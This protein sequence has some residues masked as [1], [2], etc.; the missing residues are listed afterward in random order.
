MRRIL[1]KPEGPWLIA[2]VVA[3]ALLAAALF[4]PLWKMELVAP[5]YPKGLIMKAYGDR[6]QG[7][8]ST[9]YEDVREINGLNHYIGMKPIEEVTE[10]GLFVPGVV[11][12]IAGTV[13]VSFV[14][15]K[16]KWLKALILASFWFM[17]VFFVADLQ[18]WLY[19]YGHTM[20]PDAALDTGAFTPK[21]FGTTRVW[22]FHSETSFQVGFYAMLLAAAVITFLP[23]AIRL[24]RRRHRREEAR[25]AA[26]PPAQRLGRRG[27]AAKALLLAALLGGA[28]LPLARADAQVAPSEPAG[29]LHQ[30][31]EEAAPGD[32]IFID[33]GV[34]NERIVIDKA[35]S[36]IGRNW[37]VIDGGGQGDVVTIAADGAT[38]SGFVV[39]GSGRSLSQEPAAIKVNEVDRVTLRGNRVEES[40]FGIYV[41]GSEGSTIAFNEVDP[42]GDTPIERRGHGIYMWEVSDTVVHENTIR[43][44]ADGIHLEFSERNGIGSNVVTKSRYGLHF[45]YAN[46][47][48]MTGNT[49]RDNLAGAV[50]MFSHDLLLKDN[51]FS[52]NRRG[53]TGAGILLKDVDNVFV[54]GNLLLRNKHG[55]TVEGTPQSIGATAVFLHNLLALNDTG[56]ALMSNAP[57]TFVENS[58]I[59]NTVQVKALGGE[60]ASR[61]MSTHSGGAAHEQ[62]TSTGSDQP[63]L[64]TGAVWTSNGR[65]NYWS[66]Y[67]GYDAD[68]DGVGDRAYRPEP[69]FAGQLERDETLRLFQFTPA[70]QALDVAADMFPLYRYNPV[71]EDSG[72]LMEPPEGPALPRDGSFNREL[73]VA[74]LL[75]VGAAYAG[76]A[77]VLGLDIGQAVRRGL[78]LAARTAGGSKPA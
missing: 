35:V 20:D 18:Y 72:P 40:H 15:W 7:D 25:R 1:A 65:G 38:L 10:M 63:A 30:R 34:F 73:L 69:P 57:I 24:I 76:V 28:A 19:H 12:L 48:R 67:R 8:P 11:A 68:G 54:E 21:V 31:I 66:D 27:L 36:L 41:L 26:R 60:L 44:A 14:A 74:S 22:N 52:N 33:G 49:F 39:R 53:A 23:P 64:P 77:G 61:V 59:D 46:D 37:P 4:L 43:N 62:A 55:L 71:M 32:T 51:E 70:Q 50:L 3:C 16:R 58:M 9:P 5:Q 47:N 45:M 29:S 42:G 6:F 75:L 78:S 17:P 2:A 13:L 56:L